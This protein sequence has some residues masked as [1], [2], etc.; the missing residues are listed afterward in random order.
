[1]FTGIVEEVGKVKKITQ[2]SGVV[3]FE[4]SAKQTLIDTKVGDSIAVNGVCLTA[5]AIGGNSFSFELMQQT[6]KNTNLGFCKIGQAVNLERSLKVGDRVSG[7][8]VCGHIDCLGVVRRKVLRNGSVELEI[9]VPAEFM[10]YCLPKGSISVDG[11]SLTLASIQ[12]NTFKV[13]IIPHTFKNTTLNSISPSDKLNIEFDILA[14]RNP[15]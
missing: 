11:I 12:A 3:L 4:I 14:K 15:S 8:F 13:C 1:M 7:H 6:F 10:R 2:R 9:A 5:V